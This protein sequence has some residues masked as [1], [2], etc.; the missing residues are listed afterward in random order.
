[1]GYLIVILG[2]LCYRWLF[3]EPSAAGSPQNEL[4][5]F[6]RNRFLEPSAVLKPTFGQFPTSPF[7]DQTRLFLKRIS[8]GIARAGVGAW[9]PP[10]L[11]L[12][13]HSLEV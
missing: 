8:F 12:C 3:G 6:G 5:S 7:L 4:Y 13:G 2:H 11:V 1:M 10:K 9:N